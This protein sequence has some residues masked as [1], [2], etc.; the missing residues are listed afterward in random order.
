MAGAMGSAARA[1]LQSPGA[2]NGL[3]RPLKQAENRWGERTRL[4]PILDL[5]RLI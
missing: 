1:G 3:G 5:G 4:L 2:H